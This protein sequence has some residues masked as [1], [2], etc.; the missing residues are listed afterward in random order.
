M[1][2]DVTK[3]RKEKSEH[4][5]H[6]IG[7]ITSANIYYTNQEVV[8]SIKGGNTWQTSVPGEPKATIK[9]MAYCPHPACYH[10]PYLTTEADSSKKNNL[11]NLPRD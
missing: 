11:E 1:G 10:K 9:E 7:V 8:T 6:I 4:H 2:Y 5:E 3:V